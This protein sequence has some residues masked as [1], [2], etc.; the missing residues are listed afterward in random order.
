MS[1]KT[2]NSSSSQSKSAALPPDSSMVEDDEPVAVVRSTPLDFWVDEAPEGGTVTELADGVYWLR[3]PLPLTGLDHINLYI[4][5]D[6][7]GYIIVDTGLGC[8]LSQETWED[9]FQGFM[10]GR[11]VTSVICTHLHADHTGLAG[12]ICRK[13]GAPLIMTRAEYYLC[14][15]MAADTGK[16]APEHAINFYR[17]VGL[18]EGQLDKYKARFGGFGKM[19]KPMPDGYH[20]IVHDQILQI[21]GHSW[22]VLVGSGHSPEH[23][24]LYNADLKV[25]LSGD[26]ILPNISSNVSVRPTE[27]EANPMQDWIDSCNMLRA[28]L[29][30]DTLIC[31]A[32]GIP[33]KGVH[34]RLDKLVSHHD[35]SLARL[36][37]F[38]ETPQR[39]VDVFSCLFRRPITDTNRL[40]AVGEAMAHFNCLIARGHMSRLINDAGQFTYKSIRIVA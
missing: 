27:P 11:R 30:E 21:N 10:K 19:I 33:F 24:C 35:K 12:W 29:P 9:V 36:H 34:R 20:R 22:T 3:M 28:R 4:L 5:R 31:P 8:A 17:M 39:A 37:K 32:H 16:P 25:C 6:G 14:R 23:A 40:L 26:Q 18:T 7:E 1:A 2:D 13:F 15:L 38:C